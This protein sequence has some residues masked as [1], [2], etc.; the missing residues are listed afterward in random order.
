MISYSKGNYLKSK[1]AICTHI[2]ELKELGINIHFESINVD[3]LDS[4]GE[5]L[6]IILA[7]IAEEESRNIS[8]N[9]RWAREKAFEQGKI[10]VSTLYGYKKDENK[11]LI[12]NP[13]LALVV[14]QVYNDYLSGFSTAQIADKLN[15]QGIPTYYNATWR[16]E[17][18]RRMLEMK[19]TKG[20]Q[21]CRKH[22]RRA[23]FQRKGSRMKGRQECS[24]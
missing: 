12:V 14:R 23:S 18:I 24:L 17:G 5:L 11:Q 16:A 20:M 6:I 22:I 4:K 13:D 3:T 7:S 19:N 1:E 15:E 8:E 10:M 21:S 9:I 2:R